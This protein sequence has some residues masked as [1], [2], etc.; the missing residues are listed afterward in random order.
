LNSKTNNVNELL[1]PVWCEVNDFPSVHRDYAGVQSLL[2]GA[3]V[4]TREAV[5]L[6]DDRARSNFATGRELRADKLKKA[7]EQQNAFQWDADGIVAIWSIGFFLDDAACRIAAAIRRSLL[8]V[9]EKKKIT[10]VEK[11]PLIPDLLFTLHNYY[12]NSPQRKEIGQ[13][14]AHLRTKNLTSAKNDRQLMVALAKLCIT[15]EDKF[16]RLSKI[17]SFSRE[18]R[19]LASDFDCLRLV[20][21][22]AVLLDTGGHEGKREGDS[23]AFETAI[24]LRAVIGAA[25]VLRFCIKNT[26]P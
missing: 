12:K 11:R 19:Q 14:K 23:Y 4:S 13:F 26:T 16:I 15:N 10:R 17:L 2:W 7:L 20:L 25:K 21:S 3:T 8:Q 24:T 5:R 9:V 1:H 6:V 18:H 22:R